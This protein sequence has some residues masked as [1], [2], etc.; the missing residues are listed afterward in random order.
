MMMASELLSAGAEREVKQLDE[1]LFFD[2]YAAEPAK[3][4]TVS[5]RK[6]R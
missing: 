5:K 2:A 4:A 1:K 6:R 3:P